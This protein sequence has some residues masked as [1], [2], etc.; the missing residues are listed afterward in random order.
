M[1]TWTI[2]KISRTIELAVL[3]TVGYIFTGFFV[4]PLF[5]IV[6]IVVLNDLVT[7]TLG[8]D[9]AWVSPVPERWNVGDVAKLSGAIATGW[10]ALGFSM[11][12]ICLEVLKLP[13]PQ[14]Q[15]LMFVYLI[16]SAQATIYMTR[17]RDHFWSYAP[18]RWVTI[19]TIS[20]MVV[21]SALALF[22]IMM[23]SVPAIYLAGVF[24][25]VFAA[26][27]LLD[28]MKMWIY[29]NTGILGRTNQT[30]KE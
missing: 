25:A 29:Q 21:V 13:I 24:G 6:L 20:D 9:R 4:T 1:L 26:A 3:L 2:T 16:Y 12:W 5:L 11:L 18:S 8:T 17:V 27:I 30:P 22:G 28:E 10:L 19:V 14:I 7:I 15:T 23:A